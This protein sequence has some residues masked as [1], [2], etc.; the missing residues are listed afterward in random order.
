MRLF[1]DNDDFFHI[2]EVI[3]PSKRRRRSRI[4]TNVHF[5]QN[6]STRLK[7]STHMMKRQTALYTK[8]INEVFKERNKMSR[9]EKV[10]YLDY[11][12]RSK[13]YITLTT[14]LNS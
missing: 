6:S 2:P 4:S 13:F 3:S 10:N 1:K 14:I 12:F 11:I 9:E 7:N 8:N 5:G